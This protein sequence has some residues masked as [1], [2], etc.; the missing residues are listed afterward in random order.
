MYYQPLF[1]PGS[2][3]TF[4]LLPSRDQQIPCHAIQRPQTQSSTILRPY[5]WNPEANK[6]LVLP[7]WGQQALR[8]KSKVN[9][10]IVLSSWGQQ[11]SFYIFPSVG[12]TISL[13]ID[14]AKF[15]KSVVTKAVDA[16]WTSGNWNCILSVEAEFSRDMAREEEYWINSLTAWI[17][18][19]HSV[20]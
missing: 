6:Y 14:C 2:Y 5:P 7:S 11:V 16:E 12:F 4:L 10:L 20:L 3:S 15:F 19:M 18:N 1:S 8:L 13:C 17:K 9:K